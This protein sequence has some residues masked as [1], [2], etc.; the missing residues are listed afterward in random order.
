MRARPAEDTLATYSPPPP[1]WRDRQYTVP[2]KELSL[3]PRFRPGFPRH[4]NR[5]ASA[6]DCHQH[7]WKAAKIFLPQLCALC[8]MGSASMNIPSHCIEQ[9]VRFVTSLPIS[10]GKELSKRTRHTNPQGIGVTKRPMRLAEPP[11][12]CRS[13]KRRPNH[14]FHT[15]SAYNQDWTFAPQSL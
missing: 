1:H 12:R 13:S 9:S 5:H 8:E 6:E 7:V 2:S 11:Y 3:P 4:K 10:A 14:P 15:P